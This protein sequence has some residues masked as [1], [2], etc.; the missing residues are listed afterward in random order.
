MARVNGPA[1]LAS[2]FRATIYLKPGDDTSVANGK[3]TVIRS[4]T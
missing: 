1:W 3:L 2:W 4:I